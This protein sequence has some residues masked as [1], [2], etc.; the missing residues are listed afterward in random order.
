MAGRLLAQTA[1][2]ALIAGG[3]VA[4]TKPPALFERLAGRWDCADHFVANGQAIASTLTIAGDAASGSLIV[5]HDD[6]APFAYHSLE[7][8]TPMKPGAGLRASISDAYSGMRWFAAAD[9]DGPAIA[10]KRPEGG[11]P[12]ETFGYLLQDDGSLR[13]DWSTARKDGTLALG[14]T[15]TCHKAPSP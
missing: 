14:D 15:L 10:W 2:A 6:A 13:I 5:R 4:Q 9:P 7:V 1:L 11:P 3:A 12:A 8:W